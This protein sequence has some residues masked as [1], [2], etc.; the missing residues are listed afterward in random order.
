M[1]KPIGRNGLARISDD[2]FGVLTFAANTLATKVQGLDRTKS[3][4]VFMIGAGP[5]DVTLAATKDSQDAVSDG[6]AKFAALK[7]YAD[8][9][10]AGG[11][12]GVVSG[13]TAV[14]VTHVKEGA[15][16]DD[17]PTVV[18]LGGRFQVRFVETV[19][20]DGTTG[21]GDYTALT[22]T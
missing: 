21:L 2:N 10:A 8:L 14:R 16:T 11:F 9:P 1:S 7:T 19:D 5:S 12:A 22:A 3:Y 20:L 17:A 18:K 15:G 4:A 13:V 6:I